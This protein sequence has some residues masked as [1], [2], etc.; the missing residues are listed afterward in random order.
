MLSRSRHGGVAVREMA[1]TCFLV[2]YIPGVDLERV[3]CCSVGS[4][5]GQ[6]LFVHPP[7]TSVQVTVEC[8]HCVLT[9][10]W[11]VLGH[12]CENFATDQVLPETR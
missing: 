7:S 12:T 3:T 11:H 1:Q 6:R 9:G 8:S 5:G 2:L 10:D 4:R